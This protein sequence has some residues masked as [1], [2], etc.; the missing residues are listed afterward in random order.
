MYFKSL[1]SKPTILGIC[2]VLT[3]G[4]SVRAQNNGGSSQ[5]V[6]PVIFLESTKEQ[7]GLIGPVR[8]VRTETVKLETKSGRVTEGQ[9][10]LL[11]VTTYNLKGERVDNVSYPVAGVTGTEEYTVSYTHLRAHE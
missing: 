1:Q 9:R 7:D 2:F 11:E 4:A 10:Q 3:I 8:S 5:R 6:A